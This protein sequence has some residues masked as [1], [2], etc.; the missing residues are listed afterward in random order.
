MLKEIIENIFMNK[1]IDSQSI[2]YVATTLVW[3][4]LLASS[5]IALAVIIDRLIYMTKSVKNEKSSLDKVMTLLKEDDRKSAMAICDTQHLPLLNIILSGLK[6]IENAKDKMISQASNEIIE[7]ERFISS[8][9]TVSTIAPLLGLLGTILGMIEAFGVLATGANA[10]TEALARGIA[11]AL[12]TTAAGLVI[13]IPSVV[14]YNY[15]V[16]KINK[17]IAFMETTSNEVIDILNK[18]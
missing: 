7:L 17:R 5:I 2:I 14:A 11:N 9:S 6:D 3:L 4:A 16:Q 1:A 15:F 8:L 10:D 18:K 12:F 13:A